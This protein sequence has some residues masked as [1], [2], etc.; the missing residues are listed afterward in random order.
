MEPSSVGFGNIWCVSKN[1][2]QRDG[3][4]GLGV[5]KTGEQRRGFE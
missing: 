5:K 3:V 1:L 4:N 2:Q